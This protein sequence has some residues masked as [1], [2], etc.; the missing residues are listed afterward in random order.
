M[1]CTIVKKSDCID[2]RK[3]IMQFEKDINSEEE[4]LPEPS[5]DEYALS[6]KLAFE[7]VSEIRDAGTIPFSRFF[8]QALYHPTYGYY[9]GPQAVFGREG[10]FISQSNH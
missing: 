5:H 7:L 4:Q 2:K 10:D 8:N 9:T 6:A 3:R 1:S